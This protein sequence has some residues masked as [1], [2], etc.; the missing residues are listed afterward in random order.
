[1]MS[2]MNSKGFMDDTRIEVPCPKCGKK[3]P[4]TVGKARRG[5]TLSCPGGH[6]V[7]L[8]ARDFDRGFSKVEGT[9]NDIKRRFGS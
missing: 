5:P 1:M 9:V 7:T 3:L 2:S 6:S 4:T 8:E